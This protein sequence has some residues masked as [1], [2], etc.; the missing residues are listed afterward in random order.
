APRH[1]VVERAPDLGE[2]GAQGVD[3]FLDAGRPQGFDLAGDL[4]QLLFQRGEVLRL[5]RLGQRAARRWRAVELAL[6]GGDL[7]KRAIKLRRQS[8][9]RDG[10]A[11]MARRVGSRAGE[12]VDALRQVVEV[13]LHAGDLGFAVRSDADAAL[14]RLLKDSGIEPVVERHA[15]PPRSFLGGLA[16]L[17]PHPF[18]FPRHAEFHALTRSEVMTQ[19]AGAGARGTGP[20]PSE[21]T[22]TGIPSATPDFLPVVVNTRLNFRGSAHRTREIRVFTRPRGSIHE[23]WKV[24]FYYFTV[25]Y[26]SVMFRHSPCVGYMT[27]PPEGYGWT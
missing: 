25:H 10:F 21:S 8:R 13:L 22:R 27:L 3:R 23:L 18:Y 12:M 4:A 15:G 26:E 16:R 20:F 7:G 5:R 19:S 17:R 11:E 2:L 24:L 6:A 9:R 1:G 14:R